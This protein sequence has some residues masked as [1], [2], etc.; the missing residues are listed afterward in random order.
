MVQITKI[1]S[2]TAH[3]PHLILIPGGPG[4]SSHTLRSLDILARSFNLHYV[5]FPGTNGNP[6][7]GDKGFNELTSELIKKIS[8]IDGKKFVLGHSYG[9]FFAAEVLLKEKCDGIICISTPFSEEALLSANDNYEKYATPELKKAEELWGKKQDDLNF[10]KWLSEYGELYFANPEG[11]EL[12]LNDRV[13]AN[14]F[15][16]NREEINNFELMLSKL[17]LISKMKLFIIG[18]EDKL[19]NAKFLEQDAKWGKFDFKSIENASH[20]VMF[21]QPDMVATYIEERILF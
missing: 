17:S 7:L 3:A 1:G 12:I 13:S 9:G 10:A 6:Y 2:T 21:D 14:F 19:L 16:S 20:F 18:E 11:K 5:D 8:E 4:L 15:N